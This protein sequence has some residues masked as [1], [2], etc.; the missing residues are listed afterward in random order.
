MRSSSRIPRLCVSSH[1]LFSQASVTLTEKQAHYLLHVLRMSKGDSVLLFNGRD[2]EWHA[3]LEHT[4]HHRV[5]LAVHHQ[6]RPQ[7]VPQN[8]HYFFAP[9]R[10]ERL[11]YIAQ[12]AVE[13]GVCSVR[14]VL[15]QH[16]QVHSINNRKLQAN[17]IEAAEQCGILT[18]PD[19]APIA[20]LPQVLTEFHEREGILVFCDEDAPAV[21]PLETLKSFT[22]GARD[23]PIAVLVGPEGGFNAP[24]RVLLMDFPYTVRLWLGPRILRA[25]TAGVAAL[26]LVQSVLGDWQ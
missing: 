5:S 2:G 4:G 20:K 9:V 24:E 19:V 23:R 17:M 1:S 22:A 7:S 25:D 10:G 16:T 15:T 6:N 11:D 18:L 3:S 13:M 12:K 21:S 14:P 26:A 8:M